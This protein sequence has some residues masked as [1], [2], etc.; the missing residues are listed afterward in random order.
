[1]DIEKLKYPIGKYVAPE[2]VTPVHINQWIKEIISYPQRLKQV[3]AN[4]S[5]EQ[6]AQPYRPD[7]WTGLQVIHH[8]ADSHMNAYIRFHLTLTEDTPTIKPYMEERWAQLSYI[9]DTPIV[10]SLELLKNLHARWA[11]L[12][13]S[14]TEKDFKREYHHPQY[15]YTIPLDKVLGLYAWHGN[16]HLHHIKL[17]MK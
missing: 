3:L 5:P 1:M 9:K 16:H 7:G 10:L 15:N 4:I 14:L 8:L 17:L 13:N 11:I 12:L 2:V 6:L